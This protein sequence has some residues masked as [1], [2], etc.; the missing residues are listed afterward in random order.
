MLFGGFQT[1]PDPSS[2]IQTPLVPGKAGAG[3]EGA[4]LG[5]FFGSRTKPDISPYPPASLWL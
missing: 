1:H 3:E 4:A 5:E 2:Q